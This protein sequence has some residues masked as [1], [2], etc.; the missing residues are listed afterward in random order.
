MVR[1]KAEPW[2]TRWSRDLLELRTNIADAIKRI[3]EAAAVAGGLPK[4][5]GAVIRNALALIKSNRAVS[6]DFQCGADLKELP[7]EAFDDLALVF[8]KIAEEGEWP[9]ND[10]YVP[11]S[12]I[13]KPDGGDRPIGVTPLMVALFLKSLTSFVLTWD[14][15]AMDFWEDAIKGS[16]AFRAGLYRRLTD[17][18]TCALGLETA[19]IYWDVEKFYDSVAWAKLFDWALDLNFPPQLLLVVA[20]LHAPPRV[21]RVGKVYAQP[22]HPSNSLVAGCGE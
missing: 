8:D 15:A 10:S 22:H 19:S 14:E 20:S 18:C 9:M 7:Q 3:K 21:V 4:F 11:V 17:E 16:S 5:S 1:L 6:L 2:Y 13:P 12:L